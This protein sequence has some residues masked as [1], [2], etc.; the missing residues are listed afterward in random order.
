MDRRQFL[1]H[2]A[3]VTAVSS[4]LTYAGNTVHADEGI[5]VASAGKSPYGELAASPDAN[6]ML[7]PE[8]FTSRVVAVSGTAP[9]AAST[10]WHAFPDG[11]ATFDDGN[12]GW[13]YVSNSEVFPNTKPD[14]GSVSSL[15][16]DS[17][18]QPLNA[19]RILEGSNSNCA[20]GPTPWGTWLSCEENPDGLGR[21]WEC[22]PTGT[23]PPVAHPA[24]GLWRREA[25]AVDP[26]DQIIYMTED[27]PDGR[28]YRFLPDDY[29][30][31]SKG[32]VEV[33]VVNSDNTV[34]W[35]P[36]SDPSGSSTPT[37]QQ[38]L[39]STNFPGNEG[40]WFHSGW[41]YFCTKH[42]HSVHGIN[43]REMTYQLIWQGRPDELGVEG[44]VLSGVDNITVHE[45]TGDLFVA[46]DGGNMELVIITSDGVVAP[47]LRIL[48]QDDS[49]VTG[50]AFSSDGT[51][52]YLSSQRGPTSSTLGSVLDTDND[53]T[54]IG[55]TYE[56]SGP[57]TRIEE[58]ESS[59]DAANPTTS[60]T[61]T[62]I[63][64]TTTLSTL[65]TQQISDVD[66]ASG[67]SS[68]RVVIGGTV[69]AA[70]LGALV[71]WRTRNADEQSLD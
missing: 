12:G 34:T 27:H 37:N 30:D 65:S 14:A 44:A 25:V 67:S 63:A 68:T 62:T 47:F 38:V 23:R 50:P 45:V 7:L 57:F 46:E 48:N 56:I 58:S 3:A 39:E 69:L 18:G 43:L 29:P 33:C 55:I 11:G 60:S 31:L 41:V 59:S 40:I 66:V 53:S 42:D 32:S 35:L 6:G 4:G 13:Y 64:P 71:A 2:S 8:G 21:V 9:T 70:A 28:L 1:K 10:S 17:D 52:L 16:F 19:I 5:P 36:I 51:R 20:G 15:H 54:H 26:V 22:D 24:M 61:T 49:E